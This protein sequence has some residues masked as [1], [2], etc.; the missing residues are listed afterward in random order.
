[1]P[2]INLVM[3]VPVW[4]EFEKVG[5]LVMGFVMSQI[6]LFVLTLCW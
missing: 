1:M 3:S 4:W 5:S 2:V 6:N